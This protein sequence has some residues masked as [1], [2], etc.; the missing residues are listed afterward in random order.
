[1][2]DAHD[3]PDISV[4][5]C[6]SR[7]IGTIGSRSVAFVAMAP[8]T[9]LAGRDQLLEAVVEGRD[10]GRVGLVAGKVLELARIA[11][12]SLMP[13]VA[14]ASRVVVQLPR[15]GRVLDVVPDAAALRGT[16]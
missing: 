5:N 1:M 2:R 4:R 9:L 15:A 6:R 10:Q 14:R 7:A 11:G 13:C 8:P 3:A 16:A 12:H